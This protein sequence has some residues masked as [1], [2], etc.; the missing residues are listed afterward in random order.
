MTDEELVMK[1]KTGD[2]S[3]LVSLW[4]QK[5]GLVYTLARKR[6]TPLFDCG[7][8][9]GVDMDDFMQCGFIA[10]MRAVN[11]YDPGKQFA[12][13]TYLGNTTKTE[14]DYLLRTRDHSKIDVLD[15]A[16]SLDTPLSVDDDLTAESLVEDPIDCIAEIEDRVYQQQQHEAIEKALKK[17]PEK[18]GTALKLRYYDNLTIHD[19]GRSMG[20]T[21]NQV[22]NVLKY[23]FIN[24]R[25][26]EVCAELEPFVDLQTDFY[27]KGSVAAQ[28]SPVE[29]NV[30]MRDRLRNQPQLLEEVL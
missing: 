13:S 17:I 26:P 15:N 21:Y 1:A 23:A 20:L 27:R 28:T 14:F 11:Y 10:L 24:A 30:I 25:K 6:Y 8:T 4:K 7:N 29:A 5:R 12:F 18:Q 22:R 19:I 3:A 2:E 16:I 9:R